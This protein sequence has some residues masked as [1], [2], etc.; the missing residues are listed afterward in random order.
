MT[1]P[2]FLY[3]DYG[4]PF[5]YVEDARLAILASEGAVRVTWRPLPSDAG[6]TAES[7]ATAVGDPGGLDH[8][9]AEL[10]LSLFLPDRRPD[11]R[12]AAQAAE[13]ARDCGEDDFRR[14]HAALF[15]AVFV[16]G[17]DVGDEATLLDLAEGVGI[18]REGLAAA[19]ADGRY[20]EV[21]TEVEAEAERYGVEG[22]PTMLVGR[23]KIV[24]A[25]PFNV[26]R[27]PVARAVDS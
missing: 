8:D 5:T 11:T 14:L 17:R 16:E 9:A 27:E 4:C 1:V 2:V 12:A 10:G 20:A 18:D 23:Y 7:A 15:R 22:T 13:F 26:L 25:A 24:G 3:G 19:L 6:P 21:L